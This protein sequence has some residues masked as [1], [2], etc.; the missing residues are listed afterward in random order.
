MSSS[1]DKKRKVALELQHR[2]HDG[3]AKQIEVALRRGELATVADLKA[4][5]ALRFDAPLLCVALRGR[6]LTPVAR[7]TKLRREQAMA[8]AMVLQRGGEGE[9]QLLTP[10]DMPE[11]LPDDALVACARCWESAVT[12]TVQVVLPTEAT[13]AIPAQPGD[14]VAEVKRLVAEQTGILPSRQRLFGKDSDELGGGL[15]LG[16]DRGMAVAVGAGRT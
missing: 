2:Q 15:T 5:L 9:L 6:K 4:A 1:S 8:Q 11:Q 7:G 13:I 12:F 3:S 14:T 10:Q 16:Q